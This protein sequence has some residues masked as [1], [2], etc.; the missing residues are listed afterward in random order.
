MKIFTKVLLLAS[1][2]I[3]FAAQA[4][5]L[6]FSYEGRAFNSDGSPLTEASVQF[7]IQIRSPG[8]ENCLL[9]EE[10]QAADLSSSN[11]YFTLSVGS[12]TRTDTTG[13]TMPAI[14]ANGGTT[15]SSLP[16]CSIGNSYTPS[17]TDGRSLVVLIASTASGGIFEA[18]PAIAMGRVPFATEANQVS[19]FTQGGLLRA[20]DAAGSPRADIAPLTPTQFGDF[21]AL[22]GGT[23][24]M[25]AKT[26]ASA[27]SLLPTYSTAPSVP[28]AGSLWYNTTTNTLQYYNGAAT[29]TLSTGP[30]ITAL[31]GDVSASG[32][33]AATTVVNY[34][35]GAP[36]SQIASAAASV[37]NATPSSLMGTLVKRDAAGSFAAN[38]GTYTSLTLTNGGSNLNITNAVGIN[39]NMVLPS[40]AG[41][42]GQVMATDGSGVLSWVTPLAASTVFANG[43]NSFGVGTAA[44]GNNDNYDLNIKTNNA[45]RVTVTAIGNVGIGTTSPGASLDV[46]G[47]VKLGTGG[48]PFS[49]MGVCAVSSGALFVPVNGSSYSCTGVPVGAVINCSP[50]ASPGTA[51][52]WSTFSTLNN[53]TFFVSGTLSVSQV[54]KCSWMVP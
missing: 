17:P 26:S 39:W 36:S 16:V 8:S 49:S 37:M 20:V 48:L 29:Q 28:A 4:H 3:L 54:W 21:T 10:T 25:Y 2:G 7:K 11:G 24:S 50:G 44:I 9:F 33:G 41:S 19:G 38:N 23:S 35:G 40:T 32:P 1:L 27:G 14:F 30:S 43:G 42:A 22:L 53:V 31:T 45:T 47:T 34:V 5:A 12:G 18:L 13:L 6:G 46:N 51:A 52:V 15:L